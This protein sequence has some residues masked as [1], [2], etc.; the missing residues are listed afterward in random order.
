MPRSTF[1]V[2]AESFATFG[3]MIRYL[4]KRVA[5]SQRELALQVGYHYTYMSRIENN[6]HVPDSATLMARFIPALKLDNEPTWTQQLLKLAGQQGMGDLSATDAGSFASSETDSD[7]TVLDID[8]GSDALPASL[9]PLLGRDNEVAEVLKIL[10]HP[11]VRLL[12]LSGPPGIGKTRLAIEATKKSAGMFA[13]GMKFFDLASLTDPDELMAFLAQGMKVSESPDMPLSKK[14]AQALKQKN[15]LLVLDN[16]EQLIA[17]APQIYQLLS[18]APGIKFL[19]TS[20]VPL[21]ISGENVFTVPPLSLPQTPL[22]EGGNAGEEAEI[23]KFA[24]IRLFVERAIAAQPA[25]QLTPQNIPAVVEICSRLDGLPLAIELAAA[26]IRTFSPQTMLKQFDRRFDWLAPHNRE[27]Q[28]SKQTLRGAIEWS[29]NLLSEKEQILFRRLAVFSFG[30]TV[31]TA[32][33]ICADPETNLLQPA[34]A[35]H[36]SE[37]FD[38]LIQLTDKSLLYTEVEN[39]ET[40]FKLLETIHDFAREKLSQSS[41]ETEI[42]NRHLA[43]FC[44]LAQ[45]VEV[46]IEG[47]NQ[48]FWANRCEIEHANMRAAMEWSLKPGADLKTGIRLATHLGLFWFMHSH[49][50]EGLYWFRNFLPKARELGDDKILAKLLFRNA[51]LLL[52]R[53]AHSE[54]WNLINESIELC[55]NIDDKLML[56]MALY[57]RA[58]LALVFHDLQIMK[59]KREVGSNA[60]FNTNLISMTLR[61]HLCRK[62]LLWLLDFLTT[63]GWLQGIARLAICT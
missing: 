47:A 56:G 51:D 61:M 33:T 39:E 42:R 2:P 44:N 27:A 14:L 5:L 21:H 49:F 43:C 1:V 37:I 60:A 54:A 13:H 50:I 3:E 10:R 15:M 63:G 11:D 17:A 55:R 45:Q 23:L 35:I 46:E 48:V 57:I 32:E 41:E 22:L 29:Y 59:N 20:R 4:R 24:A 16:F 53:G 34:S 6:E 12:T 58:D 25:F 26:R 30:R 36:A 31:E 38:L 62:V 9:T 52:S 18:D 7:S 19:V 8:P 28:A 40:R